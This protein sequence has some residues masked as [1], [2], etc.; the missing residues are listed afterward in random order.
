MKRITLLAALLG[1]ATLIA[2]GGS[3][4]LAHGES[5]TVEPETAKPGDDITVRGIGLGSNTEVEVFLVSTSTNIDLGE[6]QTDAEGAFTAQFRLPAGIAPG[7]YQIRAI[8]DETA[9][10]DF[11]VLVVGGAEGPTASTEEMPIRERP[12]VQTVGLVALFGI[13]AAVGLFFARTAREASPLGSSLQ[14]T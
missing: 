9:S 13:L 4:A 7:P 6:V 2:F 11:R 10:A 12:L 14:E 5:V 1:L 3:V 8:G